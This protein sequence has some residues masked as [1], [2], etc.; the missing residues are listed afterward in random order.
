[1]TAQ[2][3]HDRILD[4]VFS[5]APVPTFDSQP[6]PV[7][8]LRGGAPTS[9]PDPTIEAEGQRLRQESHHL[10]PVNDGDEIEAEAETQ[11]ETAP[12]ETP[13]PEPQDTP[14][15]QQARPATLPTGPIQLTR[16]QFDALLKSKTEPARQEVKADPKPQPA[17]KLPQETALEL[18]QNP[19]SRAQVVRHVLNVHYKDGAEN[20]PASLALV[21]TFLQSELKSARVEA[22][23]AAFEKAQTEQARLSQQQSIQQQ[24][25]SLFQ[26]GL[27][28]FHDP[29]P[30]QVDFLADRVHSNQL[31]GM[32]LTAA[33]KEAMDI[34]R[35]ALGLRMKGAPG[36]P[37]TQQQTVKGKQAAQAVV[38]VPTGQAPR[39]SD[40][41]GP[42]TLNTILKD[43][44][45]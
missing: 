24:A 34:G 3:D 45:S 39:A 36:R 2:S 43:M 35:K 19:E 42:V 1:M 8:D 14:E 20:D 9:T 38:R 15:P 18:F 33:T 11:Q 44:F 27:S 29:T 13:D 26:K 23:I 6:D 12:A 10:E 25:D 41:K 5:D 17:P 16:E 30:E 4:S 32:D 21:E 22:R 40:T 31:R 28:Q 7:T 37:T